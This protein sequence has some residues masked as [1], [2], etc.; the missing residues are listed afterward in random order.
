MTFRCWDASKGQHKNICI[1][2]N[3]IAE[4]SHIESLDDA[5]GALCF[6]GKYE[7]SYS[8]RMPALLSKGKQKNLKVSVVFSDLVSPGCAEKI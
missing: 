2:C 5:V 7:A 1:L 8:Y 3:F 6:W 4:Y